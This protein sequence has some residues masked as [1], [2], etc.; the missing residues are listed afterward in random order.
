M[1]GLLFD[2]DG[3]LHESLR[4]YAPAMQ[5]VYDGLADRGLAPPRQLTDRGCRAMICQADVSRREQVEAMVHQVEQT[6]GPISLL[7]NNAGV[8]GQALFQ[9][10]TDALWRRYFA[11][12]VDGAFHT[13]QAV[14]VPQSGHS[15]ILLP[16]SSVGLEAKTEVVRASS[17]MTTSTARV[18]Q[19]RRVLIEIVPSFLLIHTH[20]S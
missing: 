4:I 14:L 7:V 17:S 18:I 12:N 15:I 2:Y 3:T 8:A 5:A 16:G 13:I 20:P 9:D 10:I 6:L 1:T 11:V 19:V